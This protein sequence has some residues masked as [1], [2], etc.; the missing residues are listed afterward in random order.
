M[1]DPIDSIEFVYSSTGT[2]MKQHR[3]R[4]RSLCGL[5]YREARHA[6]VY[7]SGSA[8]GVGGLVDPSSGG[9]HFL[10]IFPGDARVLV[11]TFYRTILLAATRGEGDGVLESQRRYDTAARRVPVRLS[12]VLRIGTTRTHKHR[13][14]TRDVSVRDPR[15]YSTGAGGRWR[16]SGFWPPARCRGSVPRLGQG[17][18]AAATAFA[19]G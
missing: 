5:V 19:F 10:N 6:R 14:S 7:K 4:R 9:S 16:C 15:D 12:W 1:P 2:G 17:H 11:D 3:P 13:T 8:V 18:T